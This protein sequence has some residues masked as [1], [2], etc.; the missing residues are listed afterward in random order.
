MLSRDYT[1]ELLGLKDVI[2]KNMEETE[3]FI[4]LSI[5]DLPMRKKILFLQLRK[6]RYHCPHCGK[7]FPE[8]NTFLMRYQRM[9]KSLREHIHHMLV[10]AF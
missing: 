5:K 8:E 9:S 10:Y 1:T 3:D 4:K 7:N 2:V 6:R